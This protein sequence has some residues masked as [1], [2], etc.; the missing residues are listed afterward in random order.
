MSQFRGEKCLRLRKAGVSI[1]ETGYK[2]GGKL[3]RPTKR[4]IEERDEVKLICLKCR[5]SHCVYERKN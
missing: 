3:G 1:S 2:G 5:Y 4:T